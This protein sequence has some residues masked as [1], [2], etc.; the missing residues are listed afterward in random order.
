MHFLKMYI[1]YVKILLT[2]I[3]IKIQN[4]L[5]T[6]KKLAL[7]YIT[8]LL[9]TLTLSYHQ[10]NWIFLTHKILS[11][12]KVTAFA[13]GKSIQMFNCLD[14]SQI[15]PFPRVHWPEKAHVVPLWTYHVT[16]KTVH[17]HPIKIFSYH[18]FLIN[19]LDSFIKKQLS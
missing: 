4:S 5:I 13:K 12:L 16:R 1:T 9:P 7:P 11:N 8:T 17:V 19:I 3:T 15:G 18:H 6:A 10:L 14:N 2:N